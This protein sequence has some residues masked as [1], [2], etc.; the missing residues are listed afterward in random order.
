YVLPVYKISYLY[1][2]LIGAFIVV[3]V[4]YLASFLLSYFIDVP[5]VQPEQ[6]S[7]FVRK[8]Y[9]K[10]TNTSE[11][12][13]PFYPESWERGSHLIVPVSPSNDARKPDPDIDGL[14]K[15]NAMPSPVERTVPWSRALRAD[16]ASQL[17]ST[18][19]DT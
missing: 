4:G 11:G 2:P 3:A 7:P 10:S 15:N 12:T 1:F 5:D 13:K 9:F 14:P 17:R 16:V 18:R 6:V 8:L 19:S